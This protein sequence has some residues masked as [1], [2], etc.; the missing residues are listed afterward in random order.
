MLVT[1]LALGEEAVHPS[2]RAQTWPQYGA[3]TTK[4]VQKPY[5]ASTRACFFEESRGN[6]KRPSNERRRSGRDQE[7]FQ[8]KVQVY[9]LSDGRIS[10]QD[11]DESK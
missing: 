9:V 1:A 8:R 10:Q 7:T 6:A 4:L 11:R 5:I 3:T 2:P